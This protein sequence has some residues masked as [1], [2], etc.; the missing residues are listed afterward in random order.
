M[1]KK[2][3][4]YSQKSAS[5]KSDAAKKEEYTESRN[6]SEKSVAV[7]EKPSAKHSKQHA[8]PTYEQVAER[9]KSLWQQR[10][11]PPNQDEQIWYDAE[12]QLK[13]ELASR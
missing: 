1:A 10:G 5:E 3:M 12:N 2:Q 8:A 13:K 6:Q 9:A 4:N 7:A 11:C